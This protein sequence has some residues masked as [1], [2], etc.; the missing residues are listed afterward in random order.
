MSLINTFRLHWGD[1]PD[2]TSI[3]HSVRVPIGCY[4]GKLAA[5]PKLTERTCTQPPSGAVDG[6]NS[7]SPETDGPSAR[8]TLAITNEVP[9]TRIQLR[10]GAVL[11]VIFQLA[12][13]VENFSSFPA[14]RG[15]HLLNVFVGLMAFVATFTDLVRRHWREGCVAV[16]VI[17]I[18]STTRIGID[19]RA[20]TPL[21]ISIVLLVIGVGT[22]APWEGGWQASIGWVG[23]ICFA[24]LEAMVPARDPQLFLHWISLLLVV[25]VAQANTRLQKGYRRQIAEK[26]AAL[27]T[28]HRELRNQM[29][30]SDSLAKQR[31]TALHRLAERESTLRQIFDSSLDVI[32]A[33]RYS[34]GAY[35]RV[36]Q[37]FGQVTG[38]APEEVLGVPSSQTGLWTDLEGAPSSSANSSTTDVYGTWSRAS[39]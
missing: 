30:L 13:L 1:I 35:V 25:A 3:A 34:D 8:E 28:H 5:A 14:T 2:G 37:Q 9:G 36:N 22:L 4:E 39:A 10:A 24:I 15:L 11:V 7:G 16:C 33:T 38:Y 18:L 20:F 21:F 19:S 27:E 29:E 23:I 26:I 12:Y 31:E 32:V 17:L 6:R